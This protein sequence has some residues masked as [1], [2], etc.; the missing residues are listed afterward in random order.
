MEK[1]AIVLVFLHWP[2]SDCVEVGRIAI[3]ILGQPP[4]IGVE[5]LEIIIGRAIAHICR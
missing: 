2:K 1:Q 4:S 5:I 3:P